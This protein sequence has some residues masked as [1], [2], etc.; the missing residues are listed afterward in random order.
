MVKS[1]PNITNEQLATIK[2]EFQLLLTECCKAENEEECF[3]EKVRI[4]KRIRAPQ[5][6]LNFQAASVNSGE[7]IA[8]KAL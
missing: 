6:K 2:T 1:N 7:P 3:K 4:V 8:K 5:S